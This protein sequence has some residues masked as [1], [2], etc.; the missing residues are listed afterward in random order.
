MKKLFYILFFCT[1]SIFSEAQFPINATNGTPGS[2]I[3]TRGRLS[4]DSLLQINTTCFADTTAANRGRIDEIPGAMIRLCTNSIMLRNTTATKWIGIGGAGSISTVTFF[5]DSTMII[6]Y[7]SGVCDTISTVNNVFTT[8]NTI[9]CNSLLQPGYVTW[10]RTGLTFNV[11]NGIAN[12]NCVTYKFDS[13]TVT[14]ANGGALG[15]FDVIYVDTNRAIGVI[16]GV[17]A[18]DPQVPQVDPAS[19]LVLTYVL[20]AAGAT[21][22]TTIF[23]EDIYNEN[24]GTPNEWATSQNL[25]TSTTPADF[26]NTLFPYNLVKAISVSNS[27]TAGSTSFMAFLTNDTLLVSKGYQTLKFYVRL[28]AAFNANQGFSF[29]FTNS[30]SSPVTNI[31]NVLPGVFTFGRTVTGVYQAVVISMSAFVFTDTGFSRL[32]I[33]PINGA[34]NFYMDWIQLQGGLE[35]GFQTGNFIWNQQSG[36]RL[37]NFWMNGIGRTDGWFT[38]PGTGGA[39]KFGLGSAASGGGNAFGA[40]SSA[41]NGGFSGGFGTQSN[42]SIGIGNYVVALPGSVVVGHG[43]IHT[44][45]GVTNVGLAITSTSGNQGNYGQG[46]TNSSSNGQTFGFYN[47]LSGLSN[48]SFGITDTITHNYS[49]IF[50]NRLKTTANF[51]LLFGDGDRSS[52][53]GITDVYFGS[54]IVNPQAGDFSINITGEEGTDIAGHALNLKSG[55]GTGAAATGSKINFY[56]S[57]PGASGSTAQSFTPKASIDNNTGLSLSGIRFEEDTAINIAAANDLTLLNGN[58]FTITGNTQVNAIT[59]TNWQPGSKVTLKFTGT[60][61]VK[62][63]TAGGGSTA[64]ILLAGAVDFVAAPNDIIT[65]VLKD[66]YWSEAARKLASSSGVYTASNLTGNG[67]GVYKTTVAN[68]FQFKRL[69]AGTGMTITDNTDSVTISTSAI[70]GITADNGLTAN[71]STNVRLGGSLIQATT[72]SGGSFNLSITGTANQPVVA[73]TNTNANGQAL[74]ATAGLNGYAITTFSPGAAGIQINR[75]GEFNSNAPTLLEINRTYS[76]GNGG[77]GIGG[78]IDFNF[79]ASDG[80]TYLANN[81]ISKFTT[82]TVGSRTSQFIITGVNSAVT[83]DIAYFNG[84]G[85]VGIGDATASATRLNVVD[86]SVGAASIV[87][88]SSTS[89]AAASN[90]QKGINVSLSGANAT[91]S[92]TTY[93]IYVENTHSGTTP[94]N[95]GVYATIS[96]S[97]SNGYALYG[98][99]VTNQTGVGGT[100]SSGTGVVGTSGSGNGVQGNSTSSVGGSFFSSSNYATE[101]QSTTGVASLHIINPSSTN[102]IA[103]VLRI[104]RQSSGT[105]AN[106]IGASIPFHPETSTGNVSPSASIASTWTDVVNATRTGD[107][108]FWTTN[109]ATPTKQLVIE[110]DGRIYGT[111]LHNSAGAVTGTTNQYLASG[112]YTPGLTN[113]TNVAAS[114]AYACQWIRV[115]NVV[116][117]SG[118]VDIDVTGVG[119]TELGLALPI[120][121]AMTVEENLGGDAVSAAA[122]S[123]SAAV[124]ADATNDRAAI[125]F[126]ATSLTNDSYF[127]T[128]TYL[129]K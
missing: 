55:A 40:S 59:T 75:D 92:Q 103:E 53:L 115:G 54:G 124:R 8:N 46:H 45:T 9:G 91:A 12:I 37:E 98:N 128:F 50:G 89:T 110:G 88:I 113:V 85:M 107:L 116:T 42:S 44:S 90:L 79:E 43:G 32:V 31:V 126:T 20:V 25:W 102:T 28:N 52:A 33:K 23:T 10:S 60:P 70:T 112:T 2:G 108:Q 119:A 13:A 94:Q 111:G 100:S 61:T 84:N 77:N 38:S 66:G 19:Q 101:S 68:D 41:I 69:K 39:E 15:R 96:N 11:S 71:T 1:A 16:Q 67:I 95:Y 29:Q 120:A 127:F 36:A 27:G 6:C 14:L 125:V 117:V 17:E 83:G 129:I 65:L 48:L 63:A 86:N 106:G 57:N 5:T 123:L 118:K 51:Q 109:S 26:N 80:S 73:I 99:A 121:S 97:A 58:V 35:D 21:T 114:T 72:I 62:Y 49:H 24:L 82:A 22:P 47:R 93:G 7:S 3:L 64:S 74:S 34:K 76:G 4:I 104:N 30:A 18:A 87:N 122:A 78:S 56:T 105:P 81:L